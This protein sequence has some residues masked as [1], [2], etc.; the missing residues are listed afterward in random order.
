MKKT[1]LIS[2]LFL[3]NFFILET[4]GQD[5]TKM[6]TQFYEQFKNTRSNEK[7][8][9][10][11]EMND[12]LPLEKTRSLSNAEKVKELSAFSRK[13]QEL[14]MTWLSSKNV[15]VNPD[16]IFWIFNGFYIETTTDIV[17]EISEREDVKKILDS[18]LKTLKYWY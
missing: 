14:I 10:L 3:L 2:F 16:Q 4:F 18:L 6:S 8:G 1:L 7:I 5:L 9:C 12:A 13:S 11:I 17:S 15:S